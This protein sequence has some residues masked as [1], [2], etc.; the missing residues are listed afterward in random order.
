MWFGG[1][2]EWAGGPRTEWNLKE[3]F[4]NFHQTTRRSEILI[5]KPHHRNKRKFQIQI[6][7]RMLALIS[8]SFSCVH[9]SPPLSACV[10]RL[11]SAKLFKCEAKGIRATSNWNWIP[12]R[13]QTQSFIFYISNFFACRWRLLR[14]VCACVALDYQRNIEKKKLPN[15]GNFQDIPFDWL[16]KFR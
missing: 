12:F 9:L 8:L 4:S 14:F 11:A 2:S 5:R 13:P 16:I 6:S 10:F 7:R 3:T 15:R 1:E